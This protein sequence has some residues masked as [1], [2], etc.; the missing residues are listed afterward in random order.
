[1]P[2]DTGRHVSPDRL[3]TLLVVASPKGWLALAVTAV[4]VAL[5]VA[6]S[7][8]GRIPMEVEGIGVLMHPQK[9]VP[10]QSEATGMVTSLMVK[11]GDTVQ[12][13][14]VVATVAQPDLAEQLRQAERQRATLEAQFDALYPMQLSSAKAQIT[15][16]QAQLDNIRKL[17]EQAKRLDP[18]L[19]AR[20]VEHRRLNSI[21]A[22]SLDQVI[23]AE[24]TYLANRN[25]I[26]QLESQ[27]RTL[28]IK[29]SDLKQQLA[30]AEAEQQTKIEAVQA[31]IDLLKLQIST[32][33]QIVSK[34]S[35]KLIEV[36]MGVGQMVASG[37]RV[38]TLAETAEDQPLVG[39]MYFPVKDG[40]KIAE[41]MPVQITPDTV[42]R[43]LYGGITGK[44]QSVS[45]LPLSREAIATML[46]NDSLAAVAA[47]G[48]P[49]IQIV[50]DLERDPDAPSG[51]RWSASRGPETT[52]TVGTTLSGRVVVKSLPPIMLAFEV[53]RTASGLE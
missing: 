48:G 36:A 5:I 42:Q 25:Q 1:M 32:Q 16:I 2:N 21:R 47:D 46:G 6:W 20:L 31:Q 40:K 13:G 4:M 35:G 29:E 38:G 41:D 30:Q 37:M 34:S 53:L 27:A 22:L 52:P 18:V 39:V 50:A 43:A 19:E 15:D 49:Q 3:E 51:F 7:F 45:L 26:P 23:S 8:L 17:I 33:G 11:V 9:I 12:A 24:Q 14:Q 28:K 44:V 10:L